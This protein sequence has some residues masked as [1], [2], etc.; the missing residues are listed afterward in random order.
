MI[1]IRCEISYVK[2][3]IY[4]FQI[5]NGQFL[6]YIHYHFLCK[7]L[8]NIWEHMRHRCWIKEW[9]RVEAQ[10]SKDLCEVKQNPTSETH[11]VIHQRN[12][13]SVLFHNFWWAPKMR[14]RDVVNSSMVSPLWKSAVWFVLKKDDGSFKHSITKYS[15]VQRM[16]MPSVK[17]YENKFG[18]PPSVV[19]HSVGLECTVEPLI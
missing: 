17:Y 3:S 4:I 2:N 14:L 7:N 19:K 18:G 10:L 11:S 8:T 13:R 6:L 5:K 12:Y 15:I 9:W 1:G 16:L